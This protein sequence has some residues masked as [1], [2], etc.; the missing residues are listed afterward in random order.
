MGFIEK[1]FNGEYLPMD[2]I[3]PDTKEYHISL[4]A[5]G[6]VSEALCALFNDTQKDLWEKHLDAVEKYEDV[7]MQHAFRQG[8]KIGYELMKDL[9]SDGLL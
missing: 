1:L 3:V 5:M 9:N 2:D 8:F 4:K 7:L 6:E